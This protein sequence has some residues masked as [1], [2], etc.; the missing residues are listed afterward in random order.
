VIV[1]HGSVEPMVR[2]LRE[3]GLDAGAFVTQYGDDTV[4]ADA[5]G[6]DETA[7][8]ANAARARSDEAPAHEFDDAASRS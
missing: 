2:W 6:G 7:V 1:T 4:E 3:Q 5:L 8:P